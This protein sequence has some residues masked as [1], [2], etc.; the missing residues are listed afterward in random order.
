MGIHCPK[1]HIRMCKNTQS[2]LQ[3]YYDNFE[4][5]KVQSDEICKLIKSLFLPNQKATILAAN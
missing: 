4:Q 5:V 1:S 3:K 2:A